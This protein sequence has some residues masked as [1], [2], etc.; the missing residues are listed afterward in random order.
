MLSWQ[1]RVLSLLDL[2]FSSL[3]WMV[4]VLILSLDALVLFHLV[5]LVSHLFFSSKVPGEY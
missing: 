5:V 2:P 3:M 4:W 1:A